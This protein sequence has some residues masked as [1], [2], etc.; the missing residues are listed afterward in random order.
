M[1]DVMM[2]EIELEELKQKKEEEQTQKLVN[3]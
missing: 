1:Y 3:S 2:N